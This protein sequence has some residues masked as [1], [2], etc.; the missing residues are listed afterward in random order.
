M[1]FTGMGAGPGNGVNS[2]ESLPIHARER[3]AREL[4]QN[5]ELLDELSYAHARFSVLVDGNSIKRRMERNR[6]LVELLRN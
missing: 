4:R 1:K 2:W 5:S 3:I 6:T